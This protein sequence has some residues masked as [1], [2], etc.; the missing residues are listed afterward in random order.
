V[1]W[2]V[3]SGWKDLLC[4]GDLND[5]YVDLLK[6]FKSNLTLWKDWYDLETPETVPIPGGFHTALS[7]MQRLGV[8]RCFRPDR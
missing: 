5:T 3:G 8:M 1:G 7:P 4:L 6:H 2:L